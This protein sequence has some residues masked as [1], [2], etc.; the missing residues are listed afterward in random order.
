M[1]NAETSSAG[2]TRS[3]VLKKRRKLTLPPGSFALYPTDTDR[4]FIVDLKFRKALQKVAWRFNPK[5]RRVRG[6]FGRD[7]TRQYLHKYVLTLAGKYY[8][9]VTFDNGD[10]WDCRVSNLRPYDRSED[11]A[12]RR[13]FKNRRRKGVSFHKRKKKF[14]AMIRVHGKLRHLG[15]HNTADLAARAYAKA[16]NAAHP[17]A[18]PLPVT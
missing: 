2:V 9:E 3:W 8:P 5:T 10:W 12:R 1:H 4:A 18:E 15:Y 7:Q 17:F 6:Y 11:G 14:V 16:W 13:L